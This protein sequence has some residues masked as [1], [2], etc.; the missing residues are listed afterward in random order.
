MSV[1]KVQ[2]NSK[3]LQT[4]GSWGVSFASQADAFEPDREQGAVQMN[5]LSK[6][7][8][9]KQPSTGLLL[10]PPKKKRGE[11]FPRVRMTVLGKPQVDASS[12]TSPD[13]LQMEFQELAT[14]EASLT[15][16]PSS[17]AGLRAL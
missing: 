10:L 12:L 11:S 15:E 14:F 7:A 5:F 13:G 6:A 17:G 2:D 16:L 9:D 1:V 3:K 4:G 8:P